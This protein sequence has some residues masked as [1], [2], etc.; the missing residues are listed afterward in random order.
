MIVFVTGDLMFTGSVT[1]IASEQGI[2]IA[3]CSGSSAARSAADESCEGV[4]VDLETNGL[5]LPSLVAAAHSRQR[6]V[7][8]YAPHVHEQRMQAAQ[9]AGCDLVLTRGQFS[10]QI[11]EILSNLRS[12]STREQ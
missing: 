6:R 7:V 12:P 5:D 8:A 2:D 3:I 4:I 9:Q 10:R 11:P 1:S